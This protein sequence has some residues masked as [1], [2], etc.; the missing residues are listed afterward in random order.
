M[1]RARQLVQ[2]NLPKQAF[3]V[4]VG[5]GCQV[6]SGRGSPAPPGPAPPPLVNLDVLND[7]LLGQA[8]VSTVVND[9]IRV[10]VAMGTFVFIYPRSELQTQCAFPNSIPPLEADLLAGLREQGFCT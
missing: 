5:G 9:T 2:P 6:S 1:R 7:Y 3:A 4:A 10:D 8:W